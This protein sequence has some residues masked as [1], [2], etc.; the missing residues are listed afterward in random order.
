MN[1]NYFDLRKETETERAFRLYDEGMDEC[2]KQRSI[3]L[4]TEAAKLLGF[5]NIIDMIKF[6]HNDLDDIFL[7]DDVL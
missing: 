6:L 1:K 4:L 7:E 5:N 3:E 2:N